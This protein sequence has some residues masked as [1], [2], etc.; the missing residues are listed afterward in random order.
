MSNS[1]QRDRH[2]GLPGAVGLGVGAIVGGGILALAGV[3]FANTGPAAMLAFGLNGLIAMLTVLSFAE[4]SSKFPESGGTYTFA[5]KVLSVEAAFS[6][7]WVV[8]FAS[9]VAG[10]LYAIGFAYFLSR[11]AADLATATLGQSPSWVTADRTV[12]VLA[13]A[14]T[15]GL[16][17]QLIRR[18]AGGGNWINIGKVIVFSVLIAGG[19]WAVA[20]RPASD[21]N[22][23]LTPFLSAGWMGLI[24]AMGYTFIALQ[25]FDLIAAVGG[26][27]R[28]P[29][30]NI[31]LAM[32]LSLTI[33]LAIYLP[34]LFVVA[35]VGTA[36]GESIAEAAAS[37]TEEIV[38]IAAQNFLGSF[39][40]WLVMVAAVLSMLS[41]LQANLFAASRIAQSM[42]RDNTLPASL[43]TLHPVRGTPVA[44]IAV[45]AVIVVAILLVLPD[46]AQAGAAASLIFLVT[47]ALA[48]WLAILVRRRS[49]SGTPFRVP[50]F[51]MVPVVGGAS[52]I[53]LA[54]FQGIVV[55]AAGMIAAIWL[56]I[57]GILFLGLFARRARIVDAARVALNPETMRLRGHKNPL[58]LVP[59]A[60]PD[61]AASLVSVAKSLAPPDIGQVLLL[62]VVAAPKQ[63][64]PVDDPQP[65]RA[66]QSVLGQALT[67]SLANGLF[68][69]AL[70]TVAEQPWPEIARVASTH[71]CQTLVLGFR[72]TPDESTPSKVNQLMSR[73]NCDIVFLRSPNDWS[74][75]TGVRRIL[76]PVAGRGGHDELLARLLGSWARTAERNVTFLRVMPESTSDA[77]VRKARR[78][79]ARTAR[80]HSFA[81]ATT[82][83]E[84]SNRSVQAVATQAAAHDLTVLGVQRV[85]RR[86]KL[87]GSFSLELA[88]LTDCPLIFISRRG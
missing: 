4:M 58:V 46:V 85:S 19:M 6:V 72:S 38:A 83:V 5:K 74:P 29:S 82:A 2:L 41:A 16:G 70:T 48:H 51:P 73:V 54:I 30:R 88:R 9:I 40:Y 86:S 21:L 25:G 43:M 10:V 18:S 7:G 62:S 60:N 67:A 52:C 32:V 84:L 87:F 42:A 39:G 69:E 33:A 53:G 28:N 26:E 23:S 71:Q 68:P 12:T 61:H 24:Q 64:N 56:S 22:S 65:L 11:V 8:W 57:G 50:W 49:V 47:F 20:G 79:L 80:D 35:T 31:P 55:P 17:L 13:V 44:S 75:E 36:A 45:T 15:I 78:E 59:I 3:A 76:V 14:T 34:L 27:V 63:W 66:A 37:H 77:E 81:N 1:L